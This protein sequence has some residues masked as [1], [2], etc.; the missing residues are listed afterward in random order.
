MEHMENSVN[1]VQ[2]HY[3]IGSFNMDHL[4]NHQSQQPTDLLKKYMFTVSISLLYNGKIKS[5]VISVVI[6]LAFR[7]LN[8]GL[9]LLNI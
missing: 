3:D 6:M 4:N 9:H 1:W 8:N 7:E 5:M 2:S